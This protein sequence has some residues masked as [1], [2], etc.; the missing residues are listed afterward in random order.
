MAHSTRIAGLPV[1]RPTVYHGRT[2]CE[3]AQ[4]PHWN[5]CILA[6]LAVSENRVSNVA[7]T[8]LN[9][10]CGDSGQSQPLCFRPNVAATTPRQTPGPLE[11]MKSALDDEIIAVRKKIAEHPIKVISTSKPM[12]VG[13]GFLMYQATI[14]LERDSDF[15]MPEGVQVNCASAGQ[16][17][18][19]MRVI[20]SS[21]SQRGPNP[22]VRACQA[23]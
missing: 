23:S 11:E 19:G 4:G 21:P 6:H 7:H 8:C 2:W 13:T 18:S 9:F 1:R 5:P 20:G 12:P 15:L 14:Y 22:E 17:V 10:L 3:Q 16:R